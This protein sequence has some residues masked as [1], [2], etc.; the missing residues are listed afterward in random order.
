MIDDEG[1]DGR[2]GEDHG[3]IGGGRGLL[4]EDAINA[5]EAVPPNK[6]ESGGAHTELPN[7]EEL[8][9]LAVEENITSRSS[10]SPSKLLEDINPVLIVEGEDTDLSFTVIEEKDASI[11][12]NLRMEEISGI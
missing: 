12:D 6:L 9:L 4:V 2:R 10:S 11:S 1:S 8:N 5:V 3:S 7:R